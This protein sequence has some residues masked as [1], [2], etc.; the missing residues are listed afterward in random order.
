VD[1]SATLADLEAAFHGTNWWD[2]VLEVTDRRYPSGHDLLWVMQDDPYIDWFVDTSSFA[3]LMESL[4][5]VVHEETHGY[6]YE[7]AHWGSTFAYWV[8][9]DWQPSVHHHSGF[10]RGEIYGML[11]DG[12]TDLYADTYLTGTQGTYDFMELL[13]ELNCYI[14]GLAALALVGE[15]EPWG[16]SARDGALALTYFLQL[17]LQR[18]RNH[19]PEFYAAIAADDHVVDLVL[20]QW[21]R[22]HYFLDISYAFPNLGVNDHAIEA[23]MHDG[24]HQGEIEQLVG[25]ELQASPCLLAGDPYQ[26][27]F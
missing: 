21:L 4:M 17:Y 26:P 23:H 14:N 10:E 9:S 2:T 6:D 20:I 15:Y 1:P 25:R 11:E 13:D 3:M 5:T 12:S 24:E 18:A 22:L 27:P 16:I 8:N 7:Y 19:Y